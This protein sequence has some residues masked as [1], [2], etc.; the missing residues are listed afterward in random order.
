MIAFIS[1]VKKKKMTPCAARELYSSDLFRKSL[2]YAEKHADKVYI[3][4]AKY[5]LLEPDDIIAPYEMTLKSMSVREQKRW[6]YSVYQKFIAKGGNPEE[7]AVFLC[8]E[9]Y[10]KY[11]ILKF[12]NARV[13][14]KGLSFGNQLKW[15]KEHL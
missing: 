13:P 6:A 5:G 4:S 10:R 12:P 14:L 15:Y 3:L 7:S 1:C 11:L 9:N 8:G 2:Q